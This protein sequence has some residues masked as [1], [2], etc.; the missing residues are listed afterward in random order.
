[1]MLKQTDLRRQRQRIFIMGAEGR[2]KN[3]LRIADRGVV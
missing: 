1:M 3:S 2:P